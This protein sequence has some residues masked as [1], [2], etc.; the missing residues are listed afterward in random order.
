MIFVT[1]CADDDQ[2]STGADLEIERRIGFAVI[3][4]ERADGASIGFSIDRDASAGQEFDV[5]GAVWR[6]DQGPWN[7]PPV[8][9][10][11]KGQRVELG[12]AQVEN[13]Q[14][15]GLLKDRVV[16][17]ACLAPEDS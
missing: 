4:E 2:S 7:E 14:R 13:A 10:I 3:V 6:I 17:I 12:I 1:A 5:T 8:A 16:W 15:P 11:A 9:C